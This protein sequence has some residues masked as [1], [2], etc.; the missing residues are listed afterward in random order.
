VSGGV[1]EDQFEGGIRF[2]LREVRR[3]EGVL[4]VKWCWVCSYVTGPVDVAKVYIV[5]AV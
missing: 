2:A 4:G 3:G 1:G 5:N